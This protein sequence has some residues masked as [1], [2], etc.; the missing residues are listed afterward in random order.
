MI[1]LSGGQTIEYG[2]QLAVSSKPWSSFATNSVPPSAEKCW[3]KCEVYPQPNCV[4]AAADASS[5]FPPRVGH[6]GSPPLLAVSERIGGGRLTYQKTL[7]KPNPEAAQA[8]PLGSKS[9][10]GLN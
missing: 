5:Y 1:W 9:G 10:S 8:W 6:H 3:Q 7:L 2:G 4:N